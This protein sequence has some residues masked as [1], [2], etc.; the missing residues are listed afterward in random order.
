MSLKI[1]GTNQISCITF[2]LVELETR[3]WEQLGSTESEFHDQ[4]WVPNQFKHFFVF[5]AQVYLSSLSLQVKKVDETLLRLV[6][7]LNTSEV[8]PGASWWKRK[9]KGYPDLQFT[10]SLG[11]EGWHWLTAVLN[12]CI[13]KWPKKNS[14]STQLIQG[15]QSRSTF[16]TRWSGCIVQVWLQVLSLPVIWQSLTKS[17]PEDNRRFWLQNQWQSSWDSAPVQLGM[18]W[19]ESTNTVHFQVGGSCCWLRAWLCYHSCHTLTLLVQ[20]F[21]SQ[22]SFDTL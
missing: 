3:S 4:G 10:S 22:K 17:I 16:T 5:Q 19:R 21:K 1:P 8:P 13:F 9:G 11:D 14:N 12:F 7:Q 20:V 6:Q 2:K 15:F 18:V